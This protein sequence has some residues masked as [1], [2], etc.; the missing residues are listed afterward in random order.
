M[1]RKPIQVETKI[2]SL[3]PYAL[4]LVITGQ[5]PQSANAY[6]NS[7]WRANQNH[8]KKWK[9]LLIHQLNKVKPQ[10]T[11]DQFQVFGIR[12]APRLFDYDNLVTS[13]KVVIDSMK[14]VIIKDDSYLMTGPW[15]ITQEKR[16]SKDGPPV[17]IVRIIK[18][19]TLSFH[20]EYR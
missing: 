16:L 19:R 11:L 7:H 2:L 4:E 15:V 1:R 9:A 13:F 6:R 3:E 5:L 17:L 14:D 12:M 8:A 18:G 20:D 10:N